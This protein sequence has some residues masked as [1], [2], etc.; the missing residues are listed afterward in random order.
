MLSHQGVGD[1][2]T[3]KARLWGCIFAQCADMHPCNTDKYCFGH[4]PPPCTASPAPQLRAHLRLLVVMIFAKGERNCTGRTV[5][6]HLANRNAR[7]AHNKHAQMLT[8]SVARS[9]VWAIPRQDPCARRPTFAL[10]HVLPHTHRKNSPQS[11]FRVL[12]IV[13]AITATINVLQG[14]FIDIVAFYV[15]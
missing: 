6:E 12:R 4:L 2:A 15:I 9:P 8:F 10:R 11:L 5:S 3:E 13:K 14:K 1:R 7:K